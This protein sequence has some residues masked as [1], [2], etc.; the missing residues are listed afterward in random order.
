MA[1]MLFRVI[2]EGAVV[3]RAARASSNRPA[4]PRQMARLLA[5]RRF[6]P[7]SFR[8]SRSAVSAPAKSPARSRAGAKIVEKIASCRIQGDGLFERGHRRF[9][10]PRSQADPSHAVVGRGK[11]A[12]PVQDFEKGIGSAPV[13]AGFQKAESREVKNLR[14]VR[15]FFPRLGQLGAGGRYSP[16]SMSARARARWLGAGSDAPSCASTRAASALLATVTLGSSGAVAQPLASR[17]AAPIPESIEC[18]SLHGRCFSRGVSC[19]FYSKLG[20]T[21]ISG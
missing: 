21:L 3:S 1:P 5:A 4:R 7:S 16:L 14:I 9:R 13:L 11:G 19:F 2:W 6:S 12:I 8:L 18:R 15:R 20:W 10:V 17:Q